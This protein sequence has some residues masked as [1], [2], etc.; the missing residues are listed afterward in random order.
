MSPLPLLPADNPKIAR[1]GRSLVLADGAVRLGF[2]GATFLFRYTGPAP[3]LHFNAHSAD[4]YFNLSCQSWNPV[5]FQLLPGKNRLPLPTGTGGPEGMTIELTRRTE[6]W[7]GL[8]D[9]LGI[10]IPAGCQLLEAPILPARKLLFIGD[11]ITCGEAVEYFPTAATESARWSNA[12]RSYGM[13]LGRMLD[14][15][16]HLVSYGGRGLVRTWED[17]T[18]EANAPQFFERALPDDPDAH[19]NHD[20]YIPDAVVICLGTNDFNPGLLEESTFTTA[21]LHFLARIRSTYP[22]APIIL[23]ESPIFPDAPEAPDIGKRRLLRA[24]LDSVEGEYSKKGDMN[25][26]VAPVGHYPG[27]YLDAHP[28][29]FQHEAIALDLLPLMRRLT[30][31]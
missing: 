14:A 30:G 20:Q 12:G 5:M 26:C 23:A 21:W 9:F 3:I 2:P 31:W 29:A 7:R 13:L 28:V 10:E 4:C 6:A 22:K 24:C 27:T 15:Q 16:V 25:V 1:M 8:C 11:S 18:D 17:K 19:W